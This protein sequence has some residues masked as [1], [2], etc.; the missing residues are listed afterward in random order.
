ML[1]GI[2][3]ARSKS[4][5][6]STFKK[7]SSDTLLQRCF[8]IQLDEAEQEIISQLEKS[9]H[10]SDEEYHFEDFEQE[11]VDEE[12]L[13]RLKFA[14]QSFEQ[15]EPFDKLSEMND[16]NENFEQECLQKAFSRRKNAFTL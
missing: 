4:F 11:E 12:I 16:T 15:E 13:N 6:P 9:I 7:K 5:S 2:T 8:S 1:H 3:T 14:V 10:L